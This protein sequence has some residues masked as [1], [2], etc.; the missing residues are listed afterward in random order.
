M[1]YNVSL[2]FVPTDCK[3]INESLRKQSSLL[4]FAYEPS[5]SG[6]TLSP[7]WLELYASGTCPVGIK[8]L[9]TKNTND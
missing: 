7:P 8:V 3:Y 1:A 6:I 4:F 9:L 2:A 5:L